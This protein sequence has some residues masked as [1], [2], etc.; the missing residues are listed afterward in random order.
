ME[1][2]LYLILII[3]AC[4]YLYEVTEKQ[5]ADRADQRPRNRRDD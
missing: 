4:V 2:A 1:N 3:A 5:A